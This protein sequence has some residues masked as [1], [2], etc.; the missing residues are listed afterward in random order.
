MLFDH[1][2]TG[3]RRGKGRRRAEPRNRYRVEARAK[4]RD[5]RKLY[6]I[7]AVVL[8]VGVVLGF[9]GAAFAG[10]LFT[11][12]LLFARNDRFVIRDIEIVDGQIKTENMIREYLAY[13]GITIGANLFSFAIREFE[14]LYLQRNPLVKTIQVS[15][16]FP[17][18]L[19]V[20]I[21]ERDPLVR[22][23]QQGSLVADSEGFV[24]RL[25]TNLHRLPVIIG[26][27]DPDLE[28]GG[29]VGG[30]A[31]AAVTL[32]AV[33][34]NPRV[35]VRVVGVDVKKKDY[36]LVHFVTPDGIKEARLSWEGMG[37]GAPE[38]RRDLIVRL[39]RLKQAAKDDRGQHS[40]F[41]ATLPGRIY[42][43]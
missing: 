10:I 16:Q 18:T 5:S 2:E 21:R 13:E 40:L 12:D 6:R 36:L 34:D 17:D 23:G 32:L 20:A 7:G 26:C 8:L 28:P 4:G 33:C 27:N 38:S 1:T 37:S 24:F 35:G 42:V 14:D 22:L 15:R 25:S 3:R 31:K 11:R 30:A 39:G 19:K 29:H 41:D 43:R 9:L